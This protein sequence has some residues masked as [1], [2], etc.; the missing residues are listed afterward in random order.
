MER[1]FV[2]VG[3]AIVQLARHHPDIAAALTDHENIIAFSNILI[4]AFAR[5]DDRIMWNLSHS[6]LAQLRIEAESLEGSLGW[7]GLR[8]SGRIAKEEPT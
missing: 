6:A 7:P 4:H 8:T 2:I 5:I 3:E 1:Q